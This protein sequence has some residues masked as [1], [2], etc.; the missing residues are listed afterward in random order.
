[1]YVGIFCRAPHTTSCDIA[2]GKELLPTLDPFALADRS[3]WVQN[4]ALLL[5]GVLRHNTLESKVD[6]PVLRCPKSGRLIA[7]WARLDN[8]AELFKRLDTPSSEQAR[9]TDQQLLLDAYACFGGGCVNHLVGDFSFVIFDP[10]RQRLFAARDPIGARPLYYHLSDTVFVFSTTAAVF[11]RLG[12]LRFAPDPAWMARFLSGVSMSHQTTGFE[13][14]KKLAPGHC[15]SVERERDML[16]SYFAFRDDAPFAATREEKWVEGYRTVLEEAHRCRLRSAY[17]IGSETSGGIDSSTVT[18]YAARLLDQPLSQLHTFGFALCELVPRHILE[19][20]YRWGIHQN[21]IFTHMDWPDSGERDLERALKVLGYPEEHSC[22]TAHIPFY[23]LCRQFGI[24]TLLSGFGGDEAVTNT[25]HHLRRE[26]VFHRSLRGLWHA[27]PGNYLTRALRMVKDFRHLRPR[28]EFNPRFFRNY[29]E[30]WLFNPV[31]EDVA[32]PLDLE[33]E[34][35]EQARYDAPY[36]KINEFIM[37]NRIHAPYVPTRLENCAL[38]AASYGVDYRWPFLDTRLIQQYLST[39]AI[40]KAKGSVGRYLHRRAVDGLVPSGVLW[41]SKEMGI[42]RHRLEAAL[43]E[44][45]KAQ[46]IQKARELTESLHNGLGELVDR[47]KLQ[48]Q[49]ALARQGGSDPFWFQFRHNVRNL[50]W[51]NCWLQG[52]V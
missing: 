8:R 2:Q 51:L 38:I 17:P 15:L 42:P 18:A 34:F 5:A 10:A 19:T 48:R 46:L 37:G 21:H 1:M 44:R 9:I 52:L 6:Q 4:D 45:R 28:Q 41:K 3:L 13:G 50:T 32:R 16:R 36:R 22:G 11:N 30:R 39:P 43:D 20:S 14:V 25:A 7:A 12:N 24:R 31:R 29:S 35:M 23:E 49:I 40:E 26:M 27:V 33:R 47:D